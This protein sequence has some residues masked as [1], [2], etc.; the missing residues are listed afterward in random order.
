MDTSIFL[1]YGPIL[2]HN[3]FFYFIE[4]ARGCG[5]T[6]GAKLLAIKDYLKNGKQ[7]MYVRRYKNEFDKI[8]EFFKDIEAAFPDYIFAVRGGNFYIAPQA[9]KGGDLFNVKYV[10]GYYGALSVQAYLKSVPFPRIRT[11][12]FDEYVIDKSNI[13]YL[14]N[15]AESFFELCF[16]IARLRNDIRVLFLSNAVSVM[17]P[18]FLYLHITP[19]TKQIVAY[20]DMLV[21]RCQ[22]SKY[23]E[24]L[25]NTRLGQIL[26][27]TRYASYAIDNVYLRD[28]SDF[29]MDKPKP[30]KYY[31]TIRYMN[32][33]YGLWIDK[34]NGVLWISSR[35]DATCKNRW[36]ITRDDNTPNTTIL[37]AQSRSGVLNFIRTCY[38]E[39]CIGYESMVVKNQFYDIIS[40]LFTVK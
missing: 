36:A 9:V 39:S 30:A 29:V 19:S 31:A 12:I 23:T 33:N 25:K 38:E 32:R 6:Y 35:H 1:D 4:G 2:S 3:K 10:A 7:F 40:L 34:Q 16:T 26:K 18:Y 20:D 27:G 21:Y 5:K 24:V 37:K 17:N 11:I 8:S 22:N 15:E 13:R 14:K 28:N